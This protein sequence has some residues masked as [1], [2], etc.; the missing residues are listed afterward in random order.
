MGVSSLPSV[1]YSWVDSPYPYR[2][3]RWHLDGHRKSA[4]N[5][6]GSLLHEDFLRKDR[7]D[8]ARGQKLYSKQVHLQ[9]EDQLTWIV[10]TEAIR[11]RR[12]IV[13][14]LIRR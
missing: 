13:L 8:N 9:F 2:L 7:L 5:Q 4:P 3:D 6:P 10:F 12:S 11:I 1:W 14:I